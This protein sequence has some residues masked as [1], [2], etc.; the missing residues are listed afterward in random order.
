MELL[1]SIVLAANAGRVELS[2][3]WC[4]ADS[5]TCLCDFLDSDWS[6]SSR[7]CEE[8]ASVWGSVVARDAKDRDANEVRYSSELGSAIVL[9]AGSDWLSKS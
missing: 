3:A 7:P 6:E 5:I 1:S 8:C 2:V 9:K 4:V